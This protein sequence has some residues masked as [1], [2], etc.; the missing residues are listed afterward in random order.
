MA[1]SDRAERIARVAVVTAG[2]SVSGG[3]VGAVCAT[4]AVG[5]I[6]TAES[7]FASLASG[8]GLGLLGIAAGA[9]AVVGMVGAPLLGWGLLRRVPLG[10][11][12]VITALG[13]VF[14]AVCGQ[15]LNPLNPY[16]HVVPGV[17]GGALAGFVVA[18]VWLRA[19]VRRTPRS[20]VA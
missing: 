18:G 16:S 3:V 11:A 12:I 1:P 5:V 13:T 20:P 2:L 6:A 9:G 8:A 19:T 7:G 17:I 4:A 10:R 15:L 14:G